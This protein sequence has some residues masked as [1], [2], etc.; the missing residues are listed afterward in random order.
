MTSHMMVHC[1]LQT[2]VCGICEKTFKRSYD[3][4]KHEITHTAEHHQVHARSRAVIYK[5]LQL[6]LP[7]E[8]QPH[9]SLQSDGITPTVKSSRTYKIPRGRSTDAIGTPVG[10]PRRGNSISSTRSS[11]YERTPVPESSKPFSN[12]RSESNLQ[13]SY[14]SGFSSAITPIQQDMESDFSHG[15]HFQFVDDYSNSSD[16]PSSRTSNQLVFPSQYP[17][18]YLDFNQPFG[19]DYTSSSNSN[20]MDRYFNEVHD[21]RRASQPA[22]LMP[23]PPSHLGGAMPPDLYRTGSLPTNSLYPNMMLNQNQVH[24]NFSQL[25]AEEQAR[26]SIADFSFLNI[27]TQDQQANNYLYSSVPD[28]QQNMWTN[29]IAHQEAFDLLF[30]PAPTTNDQAG[31]PQ[32]QQIPDAFGLTPILD[33]VTRLADHGSHFGQYFAA[34]DDQN[35]TENNQFI[36]NYGA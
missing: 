28:N 20:N 6:P 14:S 3:L 13:L 5:D 25:L 24:S 16:S 27:S 9:Q 22:F 7:T 31:Q 17:Q 35:N 30:P 21:S 15:P 11:P 23:E 26:E 18:T 19:N 34:G 36:Q 32:G 12:H 2:N 10:H 33:Q 8:I 29:P 4:R 1:P